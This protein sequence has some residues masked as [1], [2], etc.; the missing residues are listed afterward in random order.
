[1]AEQGCSTLVADEQG[2]ILDR[3]AGLGKVVSEQLIREVLEVT[4]KVNGRRCPLT[5]DVVWNKKQPC[6][7]RQPP[8]RKT[9]TQTAVIKR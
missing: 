8:L 9:F 1:M 5:H 6:H 7:R 4:G 2:R 3:L